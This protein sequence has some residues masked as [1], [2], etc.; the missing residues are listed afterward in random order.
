MSFSARLAPLI[1]LLF[2]AVPASA[3]EIEVEVGTNLFCDTREQVERFVALY[4]GD[5]QN[6]VDGVNAAERD[7]SACA[8]SSVAYVRGP[9]LATA[10]SK[11]TAFQIVKILVIGV[12][13]EDGVHAVEPASF[14]SVITVEEIGV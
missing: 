6:A 10:R 7:P 2:L 14:F 1:V 4:D 3:Q 13:A 11:N 9:K 12:V 8:V 5:T